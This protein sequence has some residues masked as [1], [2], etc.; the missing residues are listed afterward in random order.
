MAARAKW[1][2]L[3]AAALH[4]CAAAPG[5]TVE[6]GPNAER[7][8]RRCADIRGYLQ[9]ESPAGRAVHRGPDF[10]SP[11]LGRIAPPDRDEWDGHDVAAGFDILT[12]HRGWLLVEGARDD[13]ALTGKPPRPVYS[14]RGWIRGEGVR[15]G[16]QT[17][18]AF[19]RP[20]HDSDLV[21]EAPGHGLD[22]MAGIVACDG[23]WVLAR[24]RLGPPPVLRYSRSAIVAGEPRLVEGWATGICNN[25][26]TSCDGVS[27]DRPAAGPSPQP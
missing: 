20:S 27:G 11:I 22:H 14:G 25:Q 9:D 8:L 1:V 13:P 26:E 2:G 7:G 21:V 10:A 24:W 17:S 16:L 5:G 4:G 23:R 15:V 3:L 6:A 19:A 12:G 18:Q